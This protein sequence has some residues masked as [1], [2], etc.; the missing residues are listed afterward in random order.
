MCL[1]SGPLRRAYA[2]LTAWRQ[3][4]TKDA[5]LERR[6]ELTSYE[7][8]CLELAQ[9]RNVPLA[10]LDETLRKACKALKLPVLPQLPNCAISS[11]SGAMDR[12]V[13]HNH[14]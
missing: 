5:D 12:M 11:R 3:K 7:A 10:T 2:L 4:R 13:N 6:F 14:S 8:A 1:Q 9:R